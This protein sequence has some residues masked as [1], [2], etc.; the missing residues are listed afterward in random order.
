MLPERI[1]VVGA[2]AFGLAASLELIDRGWHPVIVDPTGP[3]PHSLAAS[4]DISKIVRSEYGGDLTYT[5]MAQQSM[6]RWLQLNER[7]GTVYHNTGIMRLFSDTAK[8]SFDTHSMETAARAGIA[9]EMLDATAIRQRLPM[10]NTERTDRG[11]FNPR[12]G[13]VEARKVLEHLRDDVRQAKA[14]WHIGKS[15]AHLIMAHSRCQGVVLTDG[16]RLEADHVLVAAGAWTGLLVP[17]LSHLAAATAQP[18]FHLRVADWERYSPPQ[19]S[20]VFPATEIS[21]LYALPLH[22]TEKVVKVGLHTQGRKAH[23][24]H[25]D[26]IVQEQ[27]V[28]HFRRQMHQYA[29]E[30]AASP[31]VY[32]RICLYHDTLD[33]DFLI[34]RHPHIDNLTV[35]CGGSGHGFKFTPVLG[36]LIASRIEDAFHPFAAKFRWR[37][38]ANP[39]MYGESG[40]PALADL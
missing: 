9:L 28:T 18:I 34:D 8:E 4:Q 30:M 15:V 10:F 35:A 19:F 37:A 13:Y 17:Q 2:G 27:E 31:I 14:E 21:G 40:R 11:F 1:I 3:T 33:F 29:P 22:P 36:A 7:W 6:E 26:R 38:Q 20:V 12:G 23:P 16:T 24:L 32:A 25:T 5:R 39:D